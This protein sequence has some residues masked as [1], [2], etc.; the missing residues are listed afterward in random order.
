MTLLKDPTDIAVEQAMAAAQGGRLPEACRIGDQALAEGGDPAVLNAML[1]MIRARA[2][3]LPGAIINLGAAHRARPADITIACN[4]IAALV[5]E[6]RLEEAMGIAT[7]DIAKADPTLRVARYRGFIAQSLDRF[8]EA[9]AI[10]GQVVATLPGD[11]ESWNNLGNARDGLGDLDGAIEA[12]AIAARL[13]PDVAPTRINLARALADAGRL[14]DAVESLRATAAAFPADPKPLLDLGAILRRQGRDE[15]LLATLREA[16]GR[17]PRDIDTLVA[18]GKECGAQ[19]QFD[20]A[21]RAFDAVLAIDP[22]NGEA[23]VGLAMMFERINRED[24]LPGLI[25]RSLRDGA[26]PQ[27]TDFIRALDFRRKG[28]IDEGL[29]ALRRTP[30]SI[31]PVRHANLEGQFLDRQGDAAGAFEA[32]TE[33][34]RQLAEDGSDGPLRARLFRDALASDQ[35]MLTKPWFDSWTRLGIVDERPSP[36]FLVGFP[37]SGTTLL[38]TM[39]MGHPDVEVME[40][41]PALHAVRRDFA[42]MA[43][44]ATMDEAALARARDDYFAEAAKYAPLRPGTLLVDK[45]PLHMNK[46]PLIHR[47]FPEAKFILALRH[48]CDVLLSCFMT[49]FR[50][51]NAM[52]N[53]LDLEDAAA[54]YDLSFSY[55]EQARAI[56]PFAVH[57]VRYEAM[58]ADSEA[59]LRPLIDYLGLDWRPELLDHQRTARERGLITTASFAQVVQPIYQRAAGRW[60]R[61]RP[62]LE[63]VLPL[64]EP[65]VRRFG[66]S[67]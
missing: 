57:T 30:S 34:N 24:E 4:L 62:Q 63:P 28:L 12:L 42:D 26:D 7:P 6:S 56:I 46:V 33:M 23:L 36:A 59:E 48:P 16:S 67:L 49:S 52:V 66:Y 25:A 47:L 8:D 1:G 31:A 50:M 15:E 43:A 55:W 64:L 39:L 13:A 19:L 37:R 35:A 61:Y 22:R 11:A 27:T 5:D 18:L 14:D 32:F 3:D 54:L 58:V 9:A 41:E 44:L 60:E 40:E 17:D 45:H 21:Q 65:W 38:D 29:A 20:E 2:G 51:N 53:F 10:Y